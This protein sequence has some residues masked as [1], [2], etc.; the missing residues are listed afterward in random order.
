MTLDDDSKKSILKQID[1]FNNTPSNPSVSN[2]KP[3]YKEY[4]YVHSETAK[5]CS[6]FIGYLLDSGKLSFT[7]PVNAL[8]VAF[9][10]GS[11]TTHIL[12]DN[13]IGIDHIIFNDKNTDK[14]NQ[15]IM[16]S[17]FSRVESFDFL[18]DLD[19]QGKFDLVVFNPQI[20]GGYEDGESNLEASFDVCFSSKKIDDYLKDDM[21][22]GFTFSTNVCQKEKKIVISSNSTTKATMNVKLSKLKIWNYY[23]IFYETT[24]KKGKKSKLSGKHSNIVKLRKNLSLVSA[25]NHTLIFLG[26][27]SDF[28][29]LFGDY[30]RIWKYGLGDKS[31]LFLAQRASTKSEELYVL[32]EAGSFSLSS[33]VTNKKEV[34]IDNGLDT[35]FNG[36]QTAVSDFSHIAQ[37]MPFGTTNNSSSTVKK[38]ALTSGDNNNKIITMDLSELGNLDFEYKN[39]L[40]KGVPGTG[41]SRLLNLI[42]EKK[43][44][45]AEKYWGE[46]ILRLNIHSGSSNADFMQGVA[47]TSTAEGQVFYQEKQGLILDLVFRACTAPNQV[48]V[49]ILEEVQEN[50]LN[51]LIGDL[52][53]LIEPEKRAKLQ[54]VS[55]PISAKCGF[56]LVAK[57]ID[58]HPK[59]H[60]V[61]IPNLVSSDTNYR[62]MILPDN[63]YIFC[64]SNYRDDKKI[65]EDNLLRRFDVID[66]YPD[67]EAIENNDDVQLFLKDLNLQIIK[68]LKYEMHPER[69][70]IGH[71][72]WMNIDSEAGF[73]K[74]LYK[75]FLELKE[76]REIQKTDLIT[77]FSYLKSEYGKD[78]TFDYSAILDGLDTQNLTCM[79][80]YLQSKAYGDLTDLAT[81][82][83]S[84]PEFG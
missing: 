12:L 40:L 41:K 34:E 75:A 55:E 47:V 24:N 30:E 82:K 26:K 17:R 65:I 39:I 66:V 76:I 43:L 81:K 83:E 52:I 20:G 29:I 31:Y 53:Y 46:H 3:Y 84:K 2:S 32:N 10:S 61:K 14:T 7:Q 8:D 67:I 51:E 4:F 5:N 21:K 58:A 74:A 28:P 13:N 1:E 45:L 70:E 36:M 33:D 68:A 49:L 79:A 37:E 38:D 54:G 19:L 48:F 18:G 15:D 35:L 59:T 25:D 69:Y 16:I 11:L 73:A 56:D 22:I 23:D 64:T 44:K 71:A 9:G 60:Y 42:V 50:S 72:T 6:N 80:K 63:L 27:E 62:K 77:I 57:F 78:A